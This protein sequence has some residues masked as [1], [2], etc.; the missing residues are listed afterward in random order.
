MPQDFDVEHIPT[1][2]AILMFMVGTFIII[3]SFTSAHN[4]FTS[5]V[6]APSLKKLSLA[7]GTKVFEN[8]VKENKP[9]DLTVDLIVNNS[10]SCR[11]KYGLTFV[12]ITDVENNQWRYGTQNKGQY[13]HK[14]FTKIKYGES[15]TEGIIYAEA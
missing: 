6:L 15:L 2:F 10:D 13:S 4:T 1:I 8:C 3:V 12:S 5:E 9:V 11:E 14:I 7:D